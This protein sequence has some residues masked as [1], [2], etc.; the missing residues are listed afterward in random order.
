M[1]LVCGYIHEGDA[2]LEV[3]PQCKA[4]FSKFKPMSQSAMTWADEHRVGVAEGIDA[5]ILVELRAVLDKGVDPYHIFNE[6]KIRSE[7]KNYEYKVP[8]Y[9][10]YIPNSL[11]KKQIIMDYV[12][13]GY[14]KGQVDGWK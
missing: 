10:R 1:C 8:K 2:E 11:L 4:P 12:D 7:K 6:A 9:D 14:I 13:L 3:C 5:E